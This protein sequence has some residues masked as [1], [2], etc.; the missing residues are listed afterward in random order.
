MN[1]W[2]AAS[3]FVQQKLLSG[4]SGDPGEQGGGKIF[5]K[6]RIYMN[7]CLAGWFKI[8][9]LAHSLATRAYFSLVF[10]SLLSHT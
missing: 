6:K 5:F 7:V 4:R 3:G 2:I 8:S 1:I 10:I 9:D